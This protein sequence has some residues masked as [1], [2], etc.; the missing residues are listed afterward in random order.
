[1]AGRATSVMFCTLL[2]PVVPLANAA[3]P[4][5]VGAWAS[6]T[7]DC[8]VPQERENAPFL[9]SP[10]GYD[11]HETHCTFENLMKKGRTYTAD[12]KCSV[13]GDMQKS[14]TVIVVK[15]RTTI[16]LSVDGRPSIELKRCR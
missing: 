10:K 14:S 13:E 5:F 7:K 3:E 15:D 11:R 12:T 6:D 16:S 9:V 2:L 4:T 8:R 1:M